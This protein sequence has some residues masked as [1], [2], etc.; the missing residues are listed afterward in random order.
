[1]T[2]KRSLDCSLDP[3]T[4]GWQS[5]P[6]DNTPPT[7]GRKLIAEAI[8]TFLLVFLGCGA[9]HAAVLGWLV[10]LWQVAI[11]WGL[12]IMFAAYT[13]GAT[14][15]AHLNPAVTI[16][17]AAWG[18]S[19]WREV[20]P[21][22]IA[23]FGGAFLAAAALFAMYDVN[24]RD[25]EQ[26]R[27]VMRGKPGSEITAMCYGE[28]FPNPGGLL[29]APDPVTT[30]RLTLHRARV[31]LPVAFGAELLGTAILAFVIFSVTDPLNPGRPQANLAPVFIGLTVTALIIVIAPLTQACFN[32]AR[33]F[34]PRVFASLAGWGKIAWPLAEDFGWLWVYIVAPISGA[35]LGAGI[36]QISLAPNKHATDPAG[37][38]A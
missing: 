13:C 15:G 5:E 7:V 12:A 23:Q 32:P 14:S 8:G 3:E 1:M 29:S 37:E 22:I 11:V 6:M 31:S 26:S 38:S 2:L 30:E 25:L 34:A 27:E 28:F 18:R 10:G 24:L 35:W 17:L 33:D 16:A 9:V 21:Y 19:P 4:P 20:A 36:Y